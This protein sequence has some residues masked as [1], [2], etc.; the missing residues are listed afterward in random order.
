[1]LSLAKV[2]LFPLALALPL[3]PRGVSAQMEATPFIHNKNYVLPSGKE[4]AIA[5]GE[6]RCK[7]GECRKTDAGTW[8]TDGGVPRL[9]TEI[10]L[11]SIDGK[12]FIIPEKFYKDLT[13][14]YYLNVLE[15]KGRV[16]VELK[17]GEAAGA[18]TAYFKIGGMCGF[19]RE[20]CGEVCREI[21]EKTIWHNSFVYAPD[22][23]CE[24]GVK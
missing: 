14:T 11:V 13:N 21:W 12:G 7:S 20:V 1:M 5:F 8:G 19:E 15:K 3:V 18:Y 17:G 16:L 4:V 22:P 6:R 23:Q 9:V 24:S 10:F 2:F